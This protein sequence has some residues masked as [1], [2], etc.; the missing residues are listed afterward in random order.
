M[1]YLKLWVALSITVSACS[2]L[3]GESYNIEPERPLQVEPEKHLE[4]KIDRLR[5]YQEHFYDRRRYIRLAAHRD[6]VFCMPGF[7][8]VRNQ[9]SNK[10]AEGSKVVV[11]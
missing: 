2:H 9:L 4:R 10:Q 7:R 8:S 5:L 3:P 6:A 11:L 1:K